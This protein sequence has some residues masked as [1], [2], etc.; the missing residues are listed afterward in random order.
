M[1]YRLVTLNAD[2][3]KERQV[4]YMSYELNQKKD[5]EEQTVG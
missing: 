4:I 5:I 1:K 2:G 3:I